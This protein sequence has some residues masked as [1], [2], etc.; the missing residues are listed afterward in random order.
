MDPGIS[1]GLQ[2]VAGLGACLALAIGLPIAFIVTRRRTREAI[3]S[4]SG[5]LGLTLAEPPSPATRALFRGLKVAR[6]GQ[7]GTVLYLEGQYRGRRVV[8]RDRLFEGS[9]RNRTRTVAVLFPGVVRGLPDVAIVPSGLAVPIGDIP[10]KGSPAR[11]RFSNNY[12]V[13]GRDRAAIDALFTDGLARYFA[14]NP[15]RVQVAGDRLAVWFETSSFDLQFW[16]STEGYQ[17]LLDQ[18]SA[19]ADELTL[20]DDHPGVEEGTKKGNSVT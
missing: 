11:V 4:A 9:R 12:R 17:T 6:W 2:I 16:P 10:L 15:R 8:V 13:Q 20:I 19:V 18:A 7:P 5:P 3:V 14:E 1:Q